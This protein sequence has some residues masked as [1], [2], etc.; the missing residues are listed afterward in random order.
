MTIE[1]RAKKYSPTHEHFQECYIDACYEQ[2]EIDIKNAT[3]ALYYLVNEAPFHTDL[4]DIEE[5]IEIMRKFIK[6]EIVKK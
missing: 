3:D 4:G 5:S 1:E 6:G 2:Q